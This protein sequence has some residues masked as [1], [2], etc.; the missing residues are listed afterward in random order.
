MAKTFYAPV[1]GLSKQIKKFYAPVGNL[2]KAV[3]KAYCSVGGLS[4]QFWGSGGTVTKNNFWFYSKTKNNDVLITQE[5]TQ[6]GTY[7]EW[8]KTADG[9]VFYCIAPTDANSAWAFIFSIDSSAYA[10]ISTGTYEANTAIRHGD[11]WY[12]GQSIYWIDLNSYKITPMDSILNK[13]YNSLTEVMND[14]FLKIYCDDFAYDYVANQTYTPFYGDKEKTIRKALTIF[15]FKYYPYKSSDTYFSKLYD[16]ILKNF[17][18]IVDGILSRIGNV[19][20]ILVRFDRLA[21]YFLQVWTAGSLSNNIEIDSLHNDEID[22]YTSCWLKSGINLAPSLNAEYI[23]SSDSISWQ[24]S[25]TAYTLNR[26]GVGHQDGV[27]NYSIQLSNLGLKFDGDNNI[28]YEYDYQAG[29]TYPINI[30]LSLEE[31][32]DVVWENFNAKAIQNGIYNTVYTHADYLRTHWLE[33]KNAIIQSI[34][35]LGIAFTTINFNIQCLK[36]TSSSTAYCTI[37]YQLGVD[38]FPQ[39]VSIYGSQT[40]GFNETYYTMYTSSSYNCPS[41]T[42]AGSTRVYNNRYQVYDFSS[43]TGKYNAI[44]FTGNNNSNNLS[45]GLSNFGIVKS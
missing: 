1:G 23:A 40:N 4:K 33:I 43:S 45:L 2:S 41:Y 8:K 30:G 16:Y 32:M 25:S 39:Q 42:K 37:S 24:A 10:N 35:N 14:M 27:P 13:E 15:L 3:T 34:N 38:T 6:G 29:Q 7:R 44:G 12:Y 9:L 5:S 20:I 19:D 28:N 21:R 17:D 26:I 18:S 11:T 36:S 31:D 22:G